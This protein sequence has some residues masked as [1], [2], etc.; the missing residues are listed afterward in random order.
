MQIDTDSIAKELRS[1]RDGCATD[2]GRDAVDAV[3]IALSH[4][5]DRHDTDGGFDRSAFLDNCGA[6]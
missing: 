3:S 6:R 4:Q 1:V 5:F 2:S